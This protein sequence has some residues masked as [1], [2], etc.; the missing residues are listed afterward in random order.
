M[1]RIDLVKHLSQTGCILLR[2]GGRHEIYH[3][4]VTGNSEPVP[5][6][7]AKTGVRDQQ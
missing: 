6:G 5:I 4:P 7:I 2:H 1:K 3:N